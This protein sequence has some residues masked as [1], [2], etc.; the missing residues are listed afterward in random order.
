MRVNLTFIKL[1]VLFLFIIGCTSVK[2]VQF[3]TPV[4][5]T[6]KKI[7]KQTKQT[8][9]IDAIGVYASN[10]FDAAR[11]NGFEMVNDSTVKAIIRPENTPINNSAYYSFKIWS[12]DPKSIYIQFDYP[13][14]FKHRYL[15]KLKEKHINWHAIDSS[16]VYKNG[17]SVY[18]KLNVSKDTTWVSAQEVVT[19]KDTELWY[20]SLIKNKSYVHLKSIGKTTLG[21]NLPVLDI[22]KGIKSNKPIV[23]LLTRQ[24]PPEVTGFFAYQEFLKTLLKENKLTSQFF[25]TYRVI[26]FPIVNPDGVDLGHWRH[27]AGGV[28]TNRDWSE[29]HQPEIK[30]LVKFV[31]NQSKKGKAKIVLGID[32]HSTY[33]DVFYTNKIRKTTALPNFIEDWFTALEANI[34]NY[35]VNEKAANSTKPVSKGW[36]LYG[37]NAVGITYEIGDATPRDKIKLVGKVTAEEMMKIL[38]QSN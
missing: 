35:K 21:R 17:E 9:A 3:K 6:S 1:V 28:D 16:D 33:E 37:Q 34:P 26:T 19:S 36:F 27:N 14:E 31:T 5:T 12:K 20:K 25:N 11:L 10:N 38:I 30:Q 4:D 13:K 29:Y 24:H 8:Y 32:F 7:Y 15:P 23:V 2:T 22:Y 18:V